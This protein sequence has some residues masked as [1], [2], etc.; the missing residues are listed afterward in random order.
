MTN[1]DDNMR[2][3]NQIMEVSDWFYDKHGFEAEFVHIN[4][5][6]YLQLLRENE[7]FRRSGLEAIQ[8]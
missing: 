1:Q 7:G 8:K 5:P 2:I 4:K 6:I 3:F